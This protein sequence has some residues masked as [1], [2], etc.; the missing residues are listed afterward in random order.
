[1]KLDFDQQRLLNLMKDFH[2]LTGI[3]IVLFDDEYQQLLSWPEHDCAFCECMKQHPTAKEFC[4]QS[5]ILSFSES[6]K[7]KNL[8][9][10]HCH[11]GLIEATMPLIFNHVVI[12]YL[13]FGQISD[14]ESELALQQLI[15]TSL[16][17]YDIDT[18]TIHQYLSQDDAYTAYFSRIAH[19]LMESAAIYYGD[20]AQYTHEVYH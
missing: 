3:R 1:M 16:E 10:Y 2:L 20:A 14:V 9:I 4:N 13:M 11:A 19:N 8:M 18:D 5:D 7:S 17:K 12:G 15:T 6:K